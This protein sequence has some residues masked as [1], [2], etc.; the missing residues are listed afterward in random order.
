MIL[1]IGCARAQVFGLSLRLSV[2]LFLFLFLNLFLFL[3]II[4][5][6]FS[7]SPYFIDVFHFSASQTRM[8]HVSCRVYAIV[9]LSEP[10]MHPKTVQNLR[11]KLRNVFFDISEGFGP[12]ILTLVMVKSGLIVKRFGTKKSKKNSAPHH[13]NA[14][15]SA[16]LNTFSV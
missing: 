5:S 4:I 9:M 3:L 11:G 7:S 12:K 6:C 15:F 13:D 1:R 16:S 14:I 10:P 8:Y 2:F